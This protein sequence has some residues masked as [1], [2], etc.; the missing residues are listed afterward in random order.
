MNWHPSIAWLL[1]LSDAAT[2]VING[3]LAGL[4]VG[5]GVGG[6]AAAG[7]IATQTQTVTTIA[8]MWGGGAAFAN[9]VKHFVIWH[10][11]NPMPNPF[12][13]TP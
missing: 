2:T 8:A 11:T 10:H 9:G 12:R 3:T 7:A 13:N 5:A 4:G 6:V 1:W